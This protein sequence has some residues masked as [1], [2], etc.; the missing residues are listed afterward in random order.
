[1]STT[2][3]PPDSTMLKLTAEEPKQGLIQQVQSTDT[4]TIKSKFK[5]GAKR[6]PYNHKTITKQA[7]VEALNS[8]ELHRIIEA[9]LENLSSPQS[10][11][12]MEN[13]PK[14]TRKSNDNTKKTVI[15]KTQDKSNDNPKKGIQRIRNLTCYY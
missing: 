2:T 1:M 4:K 9:K 8:F 12:D 5:R 11:S 3:N 14:R 13:K 15:D 6:S 7:K 10:V